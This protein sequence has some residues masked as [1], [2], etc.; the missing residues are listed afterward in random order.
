VAVYRIGSCQPLPAHPEINSYFAQCLSQN[1]EPDKRSVKFRWNYHDAAWDSLF[2][3]LE[4][5]LIAP[6]DARL[7]N[8]SAATG[9]KQLALTIWKPLLAAEVE[10]W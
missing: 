1:A 5:L 6:T 9:Q 10:A 3:S 7:P 4:D 2:A 8:N